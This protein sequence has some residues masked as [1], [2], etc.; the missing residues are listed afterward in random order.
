MYNAFDVRSTTCIDV[1]LHPSYLTS[2]LVLSSPM[3]KNDQQRLFWLSDN[4]YATVTRSPRFIPCT[5]QTI[6]CMDISVVL[7]IYKTKVLVILSDVA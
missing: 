6:V 2:Y 4:E 1:V 5:E 3:V 7:G